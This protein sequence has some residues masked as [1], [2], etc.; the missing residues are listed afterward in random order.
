MV[1]ALRLKGELAEAESMFELSAAILREIDSFQNLTVCLLNLSLLALQKGS[2]PVAKERLRETVHIAIE[3]PFAMGFAGL[4]LLFC[5]AYLAA[6]G[7]WRNAA[8]LH[9][10]S[11]RQREQDGIIAERADRLVLEP[12]I[13]RARG[14]MG[15]NEYQK[16]FADGRQLPLD[17]AM[18]E[19]RVLL[20]TA[21]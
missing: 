12:L 18:D 15:D 16:A 13:E 14:A 17:R 1:V 11:E 5:A 19:A 10:A 7:D 8:L 6:A 4:I 21:V 20:G 3:S 2:L 9:G